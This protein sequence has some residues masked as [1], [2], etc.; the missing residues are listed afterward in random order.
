M[1]YLFL[2]PSKECRVPSHPLILAILFL[3]SKLS[4]PHE[5]NGRRVVSD[6][7]QHHGLQALCTERRHSGQENTSERKNK[8][9]KEKKKTRKGQC[10]P[11]PLYCL[12]HMPPC[13][14]CKF[15]SGEVKLIVHVCVCVF[16]CLW[17]LLD[18][19]RVLQVYRFTIRVS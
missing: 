3:P 18:V 7:V 14:L 8:K 16:G 11:W 9:E 19:N 17:S 2:V 4:D 10:F 13:G 6:L 12:C 15:L 5:D 1:C